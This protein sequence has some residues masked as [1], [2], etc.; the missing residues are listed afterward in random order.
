MSKVNARIVHH[1]LTTDDDFK[2][3][4]NADFD[5]FNN[6]TEFD[7]ADGEIGVNLYRQKAY[8]NIDGNIKEFYTENN[9]N[10]GTTPVI[11]GTDNRIFYQSS[12]KVLQSSDLTFDGVNLG[13][14]LNGASATARL[15]VKGVGNLGSDVIARFRRASGSDALTISPTGMVATPMGA[16]ENRGFTA[17]IDD[18]GATNN[19]GIRL[20]VR[21]ATTTNKAIDIVRGDISF[22]NGTKIGLT[23]TDVFAFYGATP[24]TRPSNKTAPEALEVLGLVD[25]ATYAVTDTGTAVSFVKPTIYGTRTAPTTTALTIS[26]TGAKIGVVQKVWHNSSTNPETALNTAGGTKVA[27]DYNVSNLNAIFMEADQDGA[28][29]FT[30][31]IVNY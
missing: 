12:S 2:P 20:D 6:W 14:G 9:I 13:V 7:L 11:N 21:G 28:G 1:R 16:T 26:L 27:G 25:T 15:D 22:V 30:Y 10:V 23:A 17:D 8:V 29:T 3:A 18:T 19:V 24:I 31:W 5:E 4:P